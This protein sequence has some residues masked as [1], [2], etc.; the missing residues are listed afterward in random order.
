MS[1]GSKVTLAIVVIVVLGAIV[2]FLT[3][4][5]SATPTPTQTSTPTPTATVSANPQS[6][7]TV[8][9]DI[10]SVDAMFGAFGDNVASVDSA[11]SDK[12]ISQVQ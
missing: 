11:L 4:S 1:N 2:Y 7:T 12:A 5:S 9:Q 6:N 3:A 8:E 10:A